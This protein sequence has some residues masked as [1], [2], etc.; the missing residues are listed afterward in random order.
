MNSSRKK[1]ITKISVTAP[2]ERGLQS[3]G[4]LAKVRVEWPAVQC[5]TD[6]AKEVILDSDGG[7]ES[8]IAGNPVH[9]N[10]CVASKIVNIDSRSISCY[11]MGDGTEMDA[12]SPINGPARGGQD[13]TGFADLC[14]LLPTHYSKPSTRR[15]SY[16]LAPGTVAADRRSPVADRPNDDLFGKDE[17]SMAKSPCCRRYPPD[18]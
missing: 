2:V 16:L 10:V 9:A 14:R 17:F 3:T 15:G 13:P 11:R 12:I 8:Q 5:D 6:R 18:C 4:A 7:E 1:C